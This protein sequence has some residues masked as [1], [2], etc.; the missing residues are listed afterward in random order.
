MTSPAR[1]LRVV[2][3]AMASVIAL[4]TPA[5]ADILLEFDRLI[6]GV[7]G[8]VRTIG[9]V[10]V[11]PDL[12]GQTCQVSVIGE[13]QASVHPGNDLIVSTGGSSAVVVGVE[14]E[15]DAGIN[16][17]SQ[18]VL[19][20][21][22]VVQL[23]FGPDELSSLGFSLS[24]DCTQP[25][26]TTTAPTTKVTPAPTCEDGVT[27]GGAV[28][29]GGT[30][31]PTE[32]TADGSDCAPAS[33]T[34]GGAV[35]PDIADGSECAPVSCTDGG[36]GV[37]TTAPVDG[38]PAVACPE[39]PAN[40]GATSTTTTPAATTPPTTAVSTITPPTTAVSTTTTTAPAPA[41]SATAALPVAPA[42]TAIA[43]A[44]AYAG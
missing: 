22:I 10:R 8:S 25:V 27:T 39:P 3:V 14:D 34:D 26:T 15:V 23:R 40:Q 28:A 32:A 9:E 33:C 42:A 7:E 20:P 18:L 5:Q 30:D 19:G 13:N 24:F 43:A 16:Y 2:A 41:G 38:A 6:S 21:S 11:D 37:T 12:V 29:G 1:I 44:P 17:T 36:S 31:G 35:A 4:A